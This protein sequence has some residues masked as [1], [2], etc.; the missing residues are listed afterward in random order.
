VASHPAEGCGRP[1]AH[2]AVVP[3][4]ARVTTP[5][6]APRVC[7]CRRL[8]YKQGPLEAPWMPFLQV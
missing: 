6:A 7:C 2:T 5:R 3:C 8:G 1:V 4:C